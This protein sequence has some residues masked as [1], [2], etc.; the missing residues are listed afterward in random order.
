MSKNTGIDFT[1]KIKTVIKIRNK[2][3]EEKRSYGCK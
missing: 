3:R 2:G 1:I